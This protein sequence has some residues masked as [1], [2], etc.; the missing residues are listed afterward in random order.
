MECPIN[1]DI[2]LLSRNS[3]SWKWSCLSFRSPGKF[4]LGWKGGGW[5]VESLYVGVSCVNMIPIIALAPPQGKFTRSH[6]LM[7][8]SVIWRLKETEERLK[9]YDP[10]AYYVNTLVDID[11]EVVLVHKE[12]MMTQRKL[13]LLREDGRIWTS[14]YASTSTRSPSFCVFL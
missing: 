7:R 12:K 11:P 2:C 14:T 5:G 4:G 8:T 13:Y 6:D 1:L 10:M 9:F 3:C